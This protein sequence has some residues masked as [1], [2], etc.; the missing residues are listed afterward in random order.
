MLTFLVLKKIR[1][2]KISVKKCLSYNTL[3][4]KT[5]DNFIPG[6]TLWWEAVI[7]RFEQIPMQCCGHSTAKSFLLWEQISGT[8]NLSWYSTGPLQEVQCFYFRWTST[9]YHGPKLVL[10]RLNKG[11][12][13][14]FRTISQNYPMDFKGSSQISMRPQVITFKEFIPYV[15]KAIFYPYFPDCQIWQFRIFKEPWIDIIFMIFYVGNSEPLCRNN[16]KPK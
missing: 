3:W 8:S 6:E 14:Q 1:V 16:E 12:R 5:C 9:N 2:K 11:Y 13:T 15:F 4:I 10:T 7:S